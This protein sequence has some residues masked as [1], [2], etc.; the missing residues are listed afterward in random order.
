MIW[1]L[2]DM[3]RL[4][5]ERGAIA[6]LQAGGTWLTGTVWRLAPALVLEADIEVEGST[7]PVLLRYPAAFPN[8][9][10]SVFPRGAIG[11]WSGHQYGAAGELCLE[12][13]PDNWHPDLTG[14][15]MLE[16]AHR[17]LAAE[18]PLGEIRSPETVPSRH[19]TTLGQNLRGTAN[20]FV[21]TENLL[22]QFSALPDG[23]PA[24]ISVALLGHGSTMVAVVTEVE[25]PDGTRWKDPMVPA[26]AFGDHN[27]P[28]LALR[29]PEAQPIP[30]LGSG[31][32]FLAA[33]SAVAGDLWSEGDVDSRRKFVLLLH[34]GSSPR[35]VWLLDPEMD[36]LPSFDPIPLVPSSPRVEAGYASL[37]E[38]QVGIVGAGS[39][40]SKIAVSLAR[41]GVERFVLIDEDLL[42]PGNL[43]RHDL[44]WLAVGM[45][46]VD[47][48]ARR[49]SLVNPGACV[50]VS[51]V[52]L[53]GQEASSSVAAA[54]EELA[55]CD[56]VIDATANAAV[57]NVLAGFAADQAR[58]LVWMEVFEGGIGGIVARY[59]PGSEPS[60][61]T[62]RAR[63]LAWSAERGVPWNRDG[64]DYTSLDDSGTP[65]VADD[66]E[67]SVIAA[68]ATRFALDTLLARTPS[69][70]PYSVYVI[71]LRR[72]WIFEQPF[73]THPVDVGGPEGPSNPRGD[74]TPEAMSEN[75]RFVVSLLESGHEA[76]A[77]D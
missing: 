70:F 65:M 29:L 21:V 54:L 64:A 6:G 63:I 17:L 43:V 5:R 71:G 42:L 69:Q 2:R 32:D 23:A 11:R 53:A 3:A 56:L 49:L 40:G 73:E 74:L 15:D 16:S 68:H 36:L 61:H 19:R 9:P 51:R 52:M 38:R 37:T 22:T 35:L 60:P 72:G 7:Y 76:S 44:D 58:P 10:P 34:S 75:V 14:A 30:P 59:R 25:M 47:G 41:S 12:Y 8:C 24:K 13:G 33:L 26:R 28:G 77:P 31:A 48:L 1:F 62:M 57:F 50:T 66:A 45:H 18:R 27:W 46:K 67:V 20:R 55:G 39:V 4:D